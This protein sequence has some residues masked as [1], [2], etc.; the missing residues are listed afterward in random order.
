[1]KAGV[2][3]AWCHRGARLCHP[4]RVISILKAVLGSEAAAGAS[5]AL[6]AE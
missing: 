3:A 5:A 6:W 1:M 4:R 2:V